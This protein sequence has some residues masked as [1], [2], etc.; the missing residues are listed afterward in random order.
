MYL[1]L[2]ARAQHKAHAALADRLLPMTANTL[3]SGE[4]RPAQARTQ[5]PAGF[6]RS[7]TIVTEVGDF[8]SQQGSVQVMN[9]KTVKCCT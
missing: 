5:N 2:P 1:K 7:S 9:L 3:F 4:T 8:K 6:V